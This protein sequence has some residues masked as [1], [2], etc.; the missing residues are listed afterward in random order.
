MTK[1]EDLFIVGIGA[2]A[3][4]LDSIK[5]F[6][7]KLSPNPKISYV[8]VQHLHPENN[9][10]F[11]ELI[12]S[13]SSREI[14]TIKN[15]ESILPNHIY[16]CPPNNDVIIKD[17]IFIL[18]KPTNKALPKPNIDKF[19]SSLAIEKKE[20]AIA[21]ILSGTGK[22]GAKGALEIA[23]Y[24]GII[25]TE[26]KGAKYFDMPKYTIDTQK[27]LAS[28]PPEILADGMNHIINDKNYFDKYF[29]LED[30]MEKIFEILNKKTGIDFT[31][32]KDNTI[33]RRIKRRINETKSKNIDNYLELL[34]K[35]EKEIERLKDEF[36]IIVTSFFRD[37]EAFLELKRYL[38]NL[39]KPNDEPIRV[40]VPASATSEE[41]YSIAILIREI[42]KELQI[43]KK[44]TIFATDVSEKN[45]I[46]SRNRTFTL[47]ELEGLDKEYINRYFEYE[48]EIYKP[49]K[50]LRKMIVFSKHDII[51]DPPFLNLDLISCRNL[52]IYFDTK[53]QK[54][55]LTIFYY[56]MKDESLLFLGKSEN[57]GSLNSLFSVVDNKYKIYK[58][59]N[60][61]TKI[62][63]NTLT[64]IKREQMKQSKE[65][66]DKAKIIDI[67][68]SINKA[69]S[70]K[71]A[72]NGVVVDEKHKILFYK[73]DCKEFISLP[74]GFQTNDLYKL[75]SSYLK[76]ELQSTFNEAKKNNSVSSSKKILINP[77]DEL[78]EYVTID[79]FPLEKNMLGDKTFFVTFQKE[80]TSLKIIENE[81]INSS[82]NED[83]IVVSLNK[84]LHKAYEELQLSNEK[85]EIA[86]EELQ[87]TNE[88]LETSNEELQS[89]NEELETVN[90]ELNISNFN[91]EFM[92]KA[93]NNVLENIQVYVMILDLDLNII[94]YT[95]G[96]NKFFNI[97]N[98]KDKNFSTILINST[99]H[100]PNLMEDLK[101][102]ILDNKEISYDIEFN[103][104][105]YHFLVKKIDLSLNSH[106][107]FDEGIVLSF[108]DKTE[109]IKKDKILF[110]QSKMASMGEMIGNIAHQWR[111]PLNALGIINSHIV[112]K[113]K[114]KT[115]DDKFV[116]NFYEK[117]QK[118]INKMSSTIDDFRNFF[119]PKKEKN[120]FYI[121][122]LLED[123]K[124][125]IIDSLID[126]NI[127]FKISDFDEN[128]T[129]TTFK[130]ELIQVFIIILNNSKDAIKSKNIQNAYI[131]ININRDEEFI[132]FTITDN[133]GGID[134]KILS[135][136]FEPYF[137][138]KFEN[139]GT[140]IGLYMAKMIIEES[141]KGVLDIKNKN[142]GVETT[143]KLPIK[144]SDDEL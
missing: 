115:L 133:G 102:L 96:I 16:F 62:D 52:L 139:D 69:I 5:K 127:N 46:K 70:T 73:G 94:K 34:Q 129:L 130:N 109:I 64:Y 140:G 82:K 38:K 4:G 143:I 84:K 23:K 42:L 47:K 91:L 134:T 14:T 125:F 117:S 100:L 20:K 137:T 103:N 128:L 124:T 107:S 66:L 40:W 32:Y 8:I 27:V 97:Q 81:P 135:R 39:I 10:L 123:I 17:S 21:I 28:L 141:M 144:G 60:D 44:T 93:F 75:I 29:I 22:D 9:T 80:I 57:I 71:Y 59:S 112:K 26:D 79:V 114:D 98:S 55:I 88:E 113:Y 68:F 43:E 61:I 72:K 92:N 50:T 54:R 25:L 105:N 87:S 95:K 30:S 122:S 56:A 131:N 41:P 74:Q 89:T 6:L 116:D 31:S 83:E 99:I 3:G 11:G 48:N 36:L 58:K 121:K 101:K 108:I 19:L 90:E 119:N 110:Q 86:Y 136:I 77:I 142:D 63:I 104:R 53:L 37:K 33:I 24:G 85:L 67:D 35:D 15:G 111:Q 65:H 2:S 132:I 106:N 120:T 51:K 18:T 12:N 126:N 45:I 118:L 13:F 76:F 49:K 138:T 7:S 78:Q 1:Y